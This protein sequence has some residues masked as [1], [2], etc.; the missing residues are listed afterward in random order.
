MSLFDRY[1]GGLAPHSE[2]LSV[3][4]VV[5]EE[6]LVAEDAVSG[7]CGAVV[8]PRARAVVL[9]DA[10]GRQ[11]EFPF[12]PAAF[13]IDGKPVSLTAPP[14]ALQRPT[15]S[16]SGSVYVEP[17]PATVA[18]ASRIWVEGIHDATLLERIWGHD[19]RVEGIVVEP[20][21]GLD[22]LPA[23]LDEFVPGD[24]RRVGV[25]ADHLVPG[26]KETRIAQM[27]ARPGLLVTGH[28]FIDIWAA[29]RPEVLGISAWPDIPRGTDWKTGVCLALGIA[30]PIDLWNRI[31]GSVRTVR[32]VHTPLI[33]A[34]EQLIDFVTEP[35]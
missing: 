9:E 18:R 16:A 25:L 34:V 27:S 1:R 24:A 26:S 20:I 15:R 5:A 3:P 30:D 11:R 6:G 7:F 29:V 17:A 14:R 31:N 23:A 4:T 2:P 8:A 13:L 33:T 19:L 22:N 32:D 35:V 12:T 28:P 21:C 10:R